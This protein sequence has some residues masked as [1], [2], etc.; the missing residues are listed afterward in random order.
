MPKEFRG[1]S[2]I[3]QKLFSHCGIDDRCAESHR[4]VSNTELGHDDDNDNVVWLH[5]IKI[6][7]FFF[8]YISDYASISFTSV[9]SDWNDLIICWNVF[10]LPYS[11]YVSHF[12][13]SSLCF[14][15]SL[16]LIEEESTTLSHSCRRLLSLSSPCSLFMSVHIKKW[17]QKSCEVDRLLSICLET[18]L[19][20]R[21]YA[22]NARCLMQIMT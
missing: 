3:K 10:F 5:E 20:A 13:L 16:H 12:H 8:L 21:L 15:Y 19:Q 9:S 2:K 18:Q 4:D 1:K 17:S 11:I 7:P 22:S 14:V 6:I